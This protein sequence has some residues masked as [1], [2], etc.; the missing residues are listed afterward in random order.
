MWTSTSDEDFHLPQE[1]S[2][3]NIEFYLTIC[4][5]HIL[6]IMLGS[7]NLCT[8]GI[9]HVST[10]CPGFLPLHFFLLLLCCCCFF[11]SS[12]YFGLGPLCNFYF[13]RLTPNPSVHAVSCYSL[14]PL[15]FEAQEYPIK[16]LLLL[17]HA[18]LMWIGFSSHF[19][20]TAR[21]TAESEQKRY[22][23]TRFV[24]GWFGKLYLVGLLAVEIYGQLVHPILFT[25]RLPFLPLMLI[26]IYCAF[27]MMYSWIWQLRQIIKLH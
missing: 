6:C 4:P 2:K 21:K 9:G 27:G 22:D 26:S 12:F 3:L 18:S 17:L 13:Q 10:Y 16:F 14:F 5:A 15:L 7:W 23:K 1:I 25:E 24:I 11:F 8:D 20:T 19:A